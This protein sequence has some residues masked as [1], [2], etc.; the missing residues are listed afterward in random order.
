MVRLGYE[1]SVRCVSDDYLVTQMSKWEK[2]VRDVI[3]VVAAVFAAVLVV[4]VIGTLV[5]VIYDFARYP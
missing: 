5:V 2:I 3:I 1:I 4:E